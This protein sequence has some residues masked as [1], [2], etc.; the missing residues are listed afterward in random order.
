[1]EILS[2][3][4][5]LLS[6]TSFALGFS[7]LARNVRNSLF[8]AFSSLCLVVA[9]WSMTFVLWRIG[10]GVLR[11]DLVYQTHLL[12]NVLLAP[13][14]L[15]FIRVLLRVKDVLSKRL[16]E[17]TALLSLPIGTAIFL[18]WQEQVWFRY[19]VLF[20]P[21]VIGLQT[22]HLMVK[23]YRM[24]RGLPVR[25]KLPA[26]GFRARGGIYLGGL[27]ILVFAV[28]DHVPAIGEI[29]PSVG[30]IAL[31]FYL[32]F[33]SR[34]IT[35][36]RL[37]NFGALFSRLMVLIVIAL[38]L[39][40]IYGLLVAWIENSPGLFFLNS[41]IASF[42]ILALLDPLRTAVGYLTQRLLTQK[43]RSLLQ[44]V[45]Q[46]QAQLVG[47]TASSVLFQ[48]ILETLEELLEPEGAAIYALRGD[49]TRYQRVAMRGAIPSDVRELLVK[50]PITKTFDRLQ[51]RGDIPVLFDQ[52]IE[53]EIDRST[54]SNH[55]ESNAALI[56]AIKSLNANLLIPLRDGGVTLAFIA[57]RATNPPEPWGGNWGLLQFL[58]PYLDQAASQ[59]RGMDVFVRQREKERL[60]ALGEMAAGLAHEIRNPL[61]AIQGAVQLLNPTSIPPEDARFL[62]IIQEEVQRLNRVVTQFL[63]YSK[64]SALELRPVE[65]SAIVDRVFTLLQNSAPERVTLERLP[66]DGA[67]QGACIAASSERLIQV[68]INLVQNA[69]RAAHENHAQGGHGQ[70]RLSVERYRNLNRPSLQGI[71]ISVEDNGPGISPENLERIFIPFF[72]TS[73]QGTGLGLSICQKI[74]EAHHGRIEVESEPGKGTRFSVILPGVHQ[75]E[76][77]RNS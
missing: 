37:L 36:Q 74:V 63:D 71:S 8:L 67:L 52:V 61:G 50:H 39:A 17:I 45:R 72:T 1:M 54:S 51:R 9:A 70:V 69:F 22:F 33:I 32:Y 77:K 56:H 12:L 29:P 47:V 49:G 5:L 41:F 53:N 10:P 27:A 35:Q 26:V 46:A 30:N 23:D 48:K 25:P 3:S 14:G 76:S 65:V 55:R 75:G 24:Q 64:P 21:A 44:K 7:I 59:L 18:G 19:L 68:L 28:M 31:A 60:A 15:L 40:G 38:I 57:V 2:Q 73:P 11:D 6:L 13:F 66:E 58:F 42:L 62:S 34:A 20:Y 43:D 4:A 16:L